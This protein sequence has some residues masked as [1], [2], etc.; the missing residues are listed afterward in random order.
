MVYEHNITIDPDMYEFCAGKLT[1]CLEKH[2]QELIAIL[3]RDLVALQ[4][5]YTK[6]NNFVKLIF[7]VLNKIDE[8]KI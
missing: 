5:Y 7:S 6:Y 2:E 4:E 3:N 8:I 1:M